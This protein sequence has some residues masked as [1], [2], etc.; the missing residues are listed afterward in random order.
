[1]EIQFPDE[2][3]KRNFLTR[4][5]KVKKTLSS[6]DNFSLLSSLLDHFEKDND[7]LCDNMSGEDDTA[8]TTSAV[9]THPKSMLTDLGIYSGRTVRADG[10]KLF[11]CEMETFYQLVTGLTKPCEC[12]ATAYKFSSVNCFGQVLRVEIQCV[13]CKSKKLWASSR[14]FGGRYLINRKIIHSFICAGIISSQYIHI[15]NFADIGTNAKWYIFTLFINLL[16]T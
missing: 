7:V 2:E 3:I 13:Q 16:S 8:T 4:M 14:V 9:S 1:M 6:R 5:D 12:R 11:M 10:E 15:C